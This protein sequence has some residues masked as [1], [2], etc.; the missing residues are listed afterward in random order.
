M[1]TVQLAV[2]K[3]PRHGT[4]ESGDTLEII[5]RPGGGFSCVMVDGQGSGRGAKTLSNM[6]ITRALA[7]LKDGA[8]DGVVAR[9]V[10]DYLYTYRMG[11]VAATLNILSVDFHSGSILMTRNNPAP[12]FVLD[13]LGVQTFAD[14]SLPIGLHAMARPQITEIAI[15]PHL[16][17]VMFTDGLLKVGEGSGQD[18]ELGNLMAGWH[19]SDGRSASDLCDMLLG[20]VLELDNGMPADDVS[21]VVLAVLPAEEA[22]PVRRMQVNFQIERHGHESFDFDDS[23]DFQNEL[24]SDSE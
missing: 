15:R 20:R 19:A 22:V 18:M 13:A 6:V 21:V 1:L 16:Y 12:F 2:A 17:V 10:H 5:E 8:R 4:G 11:Q 9:G 3:V 24:D 23:D 7:Q 14:T